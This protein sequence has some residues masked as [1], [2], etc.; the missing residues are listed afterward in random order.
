MKAV[1]PFAILVAIGSMIA[2]AQ[3][4][5]SNQAL[6]QEIAAL[7]AQ[8]ETLQEQVETA[9]K[10]SVA[11]AAQAHGQSEAQ[12]RE[13]MKL[14]G[15]VSH[16]KTA[17]AQ[18]LQ[19]LRAENASLKREATR[20][21]AVRTTTGIDQVRDAEQGHFP[22]ESW[23]FAG[24]KS[25]ENALVSAI[26]SMREGD[27]KTYFNSLTPEEQ[28]RLGK[29]WESKS[30]AEIAAKHQSDVSKITSMQI[31]DRQPVSDDEMTMSVY[32]GGV[33]R[34]EKVRMQRV[35]GEWKFGGYIREPPK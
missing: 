34:T 13:L 32:I 8:G 2:A 28:A 23:S 14:R 5:K 4:W 17:G 12:T 35:E 3:L 16:L 18:E 33:D 15:E 9:A 27:P 10:A 25:P 26:W 20:G 22:R 1:T 6:H 11:E 30:E 21:G 29:Q 31:L 19:Q 7:R 24:Y